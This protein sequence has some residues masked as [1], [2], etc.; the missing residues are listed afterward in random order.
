VSTTNEPTAEE[1]SIKATNTFKIISIQQ[2][3]DERFELLLGPQAW[4]G[5]GD[6]Q[7]V[8]IRN[9]NRWQL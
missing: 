7:A 3:V 6:I 5:L 9:Q 2:L 4:L 8:Y 1:K